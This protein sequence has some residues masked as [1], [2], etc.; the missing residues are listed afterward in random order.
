[1]A[2]FRKNAQKSHF[3]YKIFAY[4]E[5]KQYFAPTNLPRFPQDQ[6]A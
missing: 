3:L 4:I 2:K 1:M 5:K 6:R